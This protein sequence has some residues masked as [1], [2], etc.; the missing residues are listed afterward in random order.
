[1]TTC[2]PVRAKSGL[3]A[4][5]ISRQRPTAPDQAP[6]PSTVR[7]ASQLWSILYDGLP[8]SDRRWVLETIAR[9]HRA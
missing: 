6:L 8:A 3:P 2:A 7:R 5:P 1:M 4:L 9:Y